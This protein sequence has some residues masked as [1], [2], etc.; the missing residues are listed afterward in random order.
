MEGILWTFKAIFHNQLHNT[1]KTMSV[2]IYLCSQ[3]KHGSRFS[4]SSCYLPT[5]TGAYYPVAIYK[6][7]PSCS[8][9]LIPYV[10]F[11]IF[12]LFASF[13]VSDE[14]VICLS[15][16]PSVKQMV[17]FLSNWQE[18]SLEVVLLYYVLICSGF[19]H[20]LVLAVTWVSGS[21][22]GL[23]ASPFSFSSKSSLK[24]SG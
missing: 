11:W 6:G 20:F 18:L 19:E 22:G 12:S 8:V 24:T 23:P 9:L 16:I 5:N 13:S 21:A 4:I 15:H 10:D 1:F 3:G 2:W 14:S 7:R 17:K